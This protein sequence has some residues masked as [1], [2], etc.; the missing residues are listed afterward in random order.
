MHFCRPNSMTPHFQQKVHSAVTPTVWPADM[1]LRKN[2]I[3]SPLRA[4]VKAAENQILLCGL[5]VQG[6]KNTELHNEY[7]K[8]YIFGLN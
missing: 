2:V 5:M 8:I 6:T 1:S 4:S 7:L 3:M